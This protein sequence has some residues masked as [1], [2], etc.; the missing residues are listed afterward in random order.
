MDFGAFIDMALENWMYTIV[1]GAIVIFILIRLIKT[2]RMYLGAKS[3]VKKAR[4]LDRKK[5]NGLQLIE[6]IAKKRKKNTNSFG[7]LSHR[8]KKLVRKY[9][10]HKIDELPIITKYAKGKLFKRSNNKL[11]I[12]IKNQKKTLK[13][14]TMKKAMKQLLEVTNKY[15]CLDEMITFLHYLPDAIL[16]DQDYDIYIGDQEVLI[17]YQIK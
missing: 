14:I 13:K 10:T 1:I 17:T 7:K 9:L 6:K 2:A 4:K 5:F 8:G 11:N 3:Y 16:D 15:E 12:I